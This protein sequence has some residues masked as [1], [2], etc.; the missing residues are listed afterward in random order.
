MPDK[1]VATVA[2]LNST[3]SLTRSVAYINVSQRL[4]LT[5]N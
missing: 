4:D 2:T 5:E 3:E 1:V